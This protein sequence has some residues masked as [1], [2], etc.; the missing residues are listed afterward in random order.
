MKPKANPKAPL[1][2][3]KKQAEKP[4]PPMPAIKKMMKVGEKKGK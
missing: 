4:K 1:P 2:M 3:A